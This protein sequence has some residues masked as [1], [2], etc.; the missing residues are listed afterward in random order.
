MWIAINKRIYNLDHI[1]WVDS[2]ICTSPF[3]THE[4]KYLFSI[5][6]SGE[7]D[8]RLLW[9]NTKEEAEDALNTLLQC[10]ILVNDGVME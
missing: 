3:Q 6:L 9:F 7:K 10:M 8:L 5:K 4:D 2:D 1:V